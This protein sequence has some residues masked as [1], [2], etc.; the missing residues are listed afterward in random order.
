MSEI[1][2][3]SKEHEKFFYSMLAKCANSDRYHQ[4]LFHCV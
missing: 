2:F 4:T 3:D 1:K